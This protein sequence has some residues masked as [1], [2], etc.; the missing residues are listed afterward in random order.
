MSITLIFAENY[1]NYTNTLDLYVIY[2]KRCRNMVNLAHFRWFF[3]VEKIFLG[4]GNF[5]FSLIFTPTHPTIPSRN[6]FLTPPCGESNNSAGKFP[7]EKCPSGDHSSEIQH[8]QSVSNL[9]I[10]KSF[11]CLNSFPGENRG[12]HW[13]PFV[14]M[15]WQFH[16]PGIIPSPPP[17]DSKRWDLEKGRNF[18]TPK[19]FRKLIF[20]C[21]IWLKCSQQ[22]TF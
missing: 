8:P 16:W 10:V 20:L 15:S 17:D 9:N 19:I 2:S 18:C 7:L 12:V 3:M 4:T 13:I 6:F 1:E 5:P 21:Q 11:Y 14:G 22:Q